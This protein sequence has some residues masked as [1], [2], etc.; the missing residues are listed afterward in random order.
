MGNKK[1][2]HKEK[3]SKIEFRKTSFARTKENNFRNRK[4]TEQK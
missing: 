2:I 4:R 3:N 1:V